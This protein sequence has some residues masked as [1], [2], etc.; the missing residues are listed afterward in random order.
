M[1]CYNWAEGRHST[2]AIGQLKCVYVWVRVHKTPEPLVVVAVAVVLHRNRPF[3][4]IN[5]DREN[6][7][8]LSQAKPIKLRIFFVFFFLLLG[9]QVI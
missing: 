7:L 9:H 3:L 8:L 2:L 6:V 5:F 1:H 4:S